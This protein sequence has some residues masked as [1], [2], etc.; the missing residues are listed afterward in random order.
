M[1]RSEFIRLDSAESLLVKKEADLSRSLRRDTLPLLVAGDFKFP[2]RSPR[3][4]TSAHSMSLIDPKDV[5][6]SAAIPKIDKIAG[7]SA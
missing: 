5:L 2:I 7:V 3:E 6:S 4:L 1:S